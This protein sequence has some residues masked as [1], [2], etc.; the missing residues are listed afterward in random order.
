MMV[1]PTAKPRRRAWCRIAFWD[2]NFI[3]SERCCLLISRRWRYRAS[4]SLRLGDDACGS[5]VFSF[6]SPMAATMTT[7]TLS[8]T[9][10]PIAQ[11]PLMHR[12]LV[13]LYADS[14][15]DQSR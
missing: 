10:L 6:L 2:R 1:L 5:M 14:L 7:S 13:F 15:H 4:T 9:L 8:T 3:A 11:Q 12:G